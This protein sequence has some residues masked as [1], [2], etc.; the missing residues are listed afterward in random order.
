MEVMR[1]QN[2]LERPRDVAAEEAVLVELVEAEV[3]NLLEH[4][5]P[6]RLQELVEAE[7]RQPKPRNLNLN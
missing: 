3:A 6:A 5:N 2:V 4:L 7:V 1:I